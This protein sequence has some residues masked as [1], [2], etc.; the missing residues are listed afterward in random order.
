MY[1][2]HK[3]FMKTQTAR[4]LMLKD[5]CFQQICEKTNLQGKCKSSPERGPSPIRDS[6]WGR[7]WGNGAQ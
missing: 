3:R 4:I 6:K 2:L 1:T 7:M 5:G